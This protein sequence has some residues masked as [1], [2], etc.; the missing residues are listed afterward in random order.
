MEDDAN[1]STLG[2]GSLPASLSR[3]IVDA[4][5]HSFV[6]IDAEG[7]ITYASTSVHQLSGWLPADL[8]GHNM[9]QFIAPGDRER[10][11]TAF[12]EM[13]EATSGTLNLPIVFEAL[14]PDGQPI[15]LEIGAMRYTEL[16]DIGD[17]DGTVFRLRGWSHNH[18][19]NLFLEALLSS[20]PFPDVA[21]P[22]CES[23]RLALFAQ[24]ALLHHG[25]DGSRFLGADGTGVPR[26]CAPIDEGPWR[27]AA[28][29]GRP[30]FATVADLPPRARLA[31]E[32][33]GYQAIWCVP[34]E[35]TEGRVRAVLSVWRTAPGPPQLGE[36][37]GLEVQARYAQLAV[38]R[39]AEHQRLIHIAGH[40]SLTGVANRISFRDCLAEALSIGEENIAVAF[41]DL[42]S[43]K[44]VN[45]TYGHQT[46]DRVLVEVAG[47]LRKALR[48]GDELARLG[49]D[50]FTVLMRNVP[51]AEAAMALAERLIAATS[52]PFDADGH[53]VEIGISIGVAL[54]REPISAD[55]ILALADNALYAA[56]TKGGNRAHVSEA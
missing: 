26:S 48:T 42:D 3:A 52:E 45:D 2:S 30:V 54:V 56:K 51:D 17:F 39:W 32:D 33:P 6:I 5:A 8:V 9:I 50:E 35:D 31:A 53:P 46:G 12:A 49:G 36:S 25:F 29:E 37:A 55:E 22:L 19:F 40:D 20:Q 4:T 10:A 15:W 11:L 43:F 38:R 34:V 14:R 27:Q 7:T 44:P 18:H 23:I 16:S 47:R 24:G 28:L 41:C 1:E 21:A 13:D